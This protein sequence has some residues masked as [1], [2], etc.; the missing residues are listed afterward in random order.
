MTARGSLHFVL[1]TL[2]FRRCTLHLVL[3][4][5]YLCSRSSL[6]TAKCRPCRRIET[7]RLKLCAHLQKVFSTKLES[8]EH[9]VCINHVQTDC[10]LLTHANVPRTTNHYYAH[11]PSEERATNCLPVTTSHYYTHILSEANGHGD[12]RQ[13]VREA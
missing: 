8:M 11:I 1:L 3:C 7:P 4:T 9:K 5:F 13:P 2:Y 6:T 10:L 12:R